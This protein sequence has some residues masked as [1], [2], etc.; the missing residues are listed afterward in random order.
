MRLVQRLAVTRL[1]RY[2]FNVGTRLV[3]LQR[4]AAGCDSLP[5]I[6]QLPLLLACHCLLLSPSLLTQ[7]QSFVF[8]HCKKVNMLVYNQ[9]KSLD[10]LCEIPP[11]SPNDG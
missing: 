9:K 10:N 3:H 11:K 5:V 4:L 8:L 6:T 7:K 1:R 2:K